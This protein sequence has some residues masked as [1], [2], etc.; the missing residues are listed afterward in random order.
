MK[1]IIE[2]YYPKTEVKRIE[3]VYITEQEA[4]ELLPALVDRKAGSL[5]SKYVVGYNITN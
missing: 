2:I 3:E 4:N 5:D 1:L